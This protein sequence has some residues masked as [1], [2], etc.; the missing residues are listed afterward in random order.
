MVPPMHGTKSQPA[1]DI[2]KPGERRIVKLRIPQFVKKQ[3]KGRQK[4]QHANRHRPRP[5]NTVQS[6]DSGSRDRR[7]EPQ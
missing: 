3:P 1:L 5:G 4:T 7:H 6:R 2:L